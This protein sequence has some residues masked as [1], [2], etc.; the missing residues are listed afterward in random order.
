MK[1]LSSLF[2]AAML[3]ASAAGLQAA[4][5]VNVNYNGGAQNETQFDNQ[6]SAT[7][8]VNAGQPT[9]TS[10]VAPA[11]NGG[12]IAGLNDGTA[13]S[14]AW[15]VTSTI[16]FNLD[17]TVNTQGYDI[18]KINS[19]AGWGANMGAQSFTLFLK[20]TTSS[21]NFVQYGLGP[22]GTDPF[23]NEIGFNEST[24]STNLS[25]L[26]TLTGASGGPIAT[27]VT[28]LQFQYSNPSVSGNGAVIREI[29]VIG[30]AAVPEP[31]T[32]ALLAFSLTAVVTLR[33][34]RR[35]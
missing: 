11:V 29:D 32:W 5:I 21:G 1:N 22:N 31:S 18:T 6:I 9:L 3:L 34:R 20:T 15:Y 25:T 24:R 30:T 13:G 14:W 23:V 2:A 35:P 28:A 10:V 26:T 4:V 12:S 19:F 7:D 16:T 8:L 27:G 33:R 17:T